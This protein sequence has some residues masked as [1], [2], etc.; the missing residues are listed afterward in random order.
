[1]S[2]ILDA[3][4]R[5]DSERERGRVPGLH[6][7]PSNAMSADGAVTGE[8]RRAG[9]NGAQWL[10]AALV[11]L[12]L[13]LLGGWLSLRL[14]E[15]R[16]EGLAP[17]PTAAPPQPAP[18]QLPPMNV[19]T[20][21]Q[22]P[23]V[24]QPQ[25]AVVAPPVQPAASAAAKDQPVPLLSELPAELRSQIPALTSGGSM[26]SETPANRMLILNGQLL[27]EGDLVAGK[28]VLEEIRLN[29]AVLSLKGQ[30]FRISY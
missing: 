27:H 19:P 11:A 14:S 23:V 2:F 28:L 22:A 30:R 17:A 25:V 4:R 29:G 24:S 12:A 7:Q 8:G 6:A 9:W 21:V 3:L 18:Q 26:Y 20:V 5:A 15:P 1:M 16:P 13:L 10:A